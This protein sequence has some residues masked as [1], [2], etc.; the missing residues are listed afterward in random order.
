MDVVALPSRTEAFGR[1]I[2]EAMAMA[3]PVVS[4]AVEGI[5]D[6]IRHDENGILIPPPPR[7]EDLAVAIVSLLNDRGRRGALGRAAR[8]SV[9]D[10]FSP[11]RFARHDL[12]HQDDPLFTIGPQDAH[13]ATTGV[14]HQRVDPRLE[15][16]LACTIGLRFDNSGGPIA[17]PA[18]V[19]QVAGMDVGVGLLER[20]GPFVGD[21]TPS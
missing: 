9:V 3:R 4:V 19:D 1:T 6:L 18:A 7:A 11:E 2:I 14:K 21:A 12:L 20:D 5:L 8:L 13:H 15:F 10:R 17:E 16:V